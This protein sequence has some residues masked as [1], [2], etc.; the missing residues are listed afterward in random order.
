MFQFLLC[1]YTFKKLLG[2]TSKLSDVLQAEKLTFTAAA[3][4]IEATV[5]IV[6]DLRTAEE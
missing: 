1:L 4:Y 3:N 2:V 6:R 5:A